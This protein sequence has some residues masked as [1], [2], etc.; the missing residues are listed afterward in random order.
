MRE[1]DCL[2]N[3]SLTLIQGRNRCI[4]AKIKHFRIFMRKP[5]IYIGVYVYT[6]WPKKPHFCDFSSNFLPKKIFFKMTLWGVSYARNRLR[7]L[8]NLQY[9][10]LTM[11]A[12]KKSE[13]FIFLKIFNDFMAKEA[14]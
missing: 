9:T 13:F 1:I 11:K 6:G 7:A 3:A 2:E 8:K 10:F 12:L 4:E 14:F 5:S